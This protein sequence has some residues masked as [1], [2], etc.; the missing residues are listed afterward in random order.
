MS[1]PE[2]DSLDK[3]S[4]VWCEVTEE[5]HA[6]KHLANPVEWSFNAAAEF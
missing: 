5:I 2:F 1:K 4:M 6:A 3:L